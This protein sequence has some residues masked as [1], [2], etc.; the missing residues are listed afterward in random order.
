MHVPSITQTNHRYRGPMETH[1]HALVLQQV[2]HDIRELYYITHHN[3]NN[4]DIGQTEMIESNMKHITHERI[5]QGDIIYSNQ[6]ST[7]IL[8]NETQHT[9]SLV[10]KDNTTNTTGLRSRIERLADTC[11][12]LYSQI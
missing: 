8:S 9:V 11:H 7:V 6:P 4:G 5:K 12:R 3:P 2:I 10:T 1:K